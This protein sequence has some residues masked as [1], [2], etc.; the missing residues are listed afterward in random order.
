MIRFG[1]NGGD[2]QASFGVVDGGSVITRGDVST[3]QTAH[4]LVSRDRSLEQAHSESLFNVKPG[5]QSGVTTMD[6]REREVRGPLGN[7]SGSVRVG[8]IQHVGDSKQKTELSEQRDVTESDQT[9]ETEEK[10][11][12]HSPPS[13][14]QT[15]NEYFVDADLP[16]LGDEDLEKLAT[17]GQTLVERGLTQEDFMD[18]SGEK[19]R[20]ARHFF[21]IGMVEARGLSKI[22]GGQ[23]MIHLTEWYFSNPQ[24]DD[25][26]TLNEKIQYAVGS[27]NLTTK[28]IALL[29]YIKYKPKALA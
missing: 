20:K 26:R 14:F 15:V 16:T 25:F 10:L 19:S 23:T 28:I 6:V 27:Q 1:D 4:R 12:I 18:K 8:G 5:S 9:G 17:N 13:S 29:T 7:Y 22:S 2:S 3:D 24:I 11:P 21:L